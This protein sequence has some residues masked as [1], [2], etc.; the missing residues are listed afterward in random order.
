MECATI[1]LHLHLD[2]SLPLETVIKLAEIQNINL[3][4]ND[5]ENLK[6]FLIAPNDCKNLVQYLKCFNLP[7]GL[8]QTQE[9]L[10]IATQD[11][12]KT[13]AN[14]GIKYAE[15]RFAPQLHTNRNITQ[16]QAIEA[17]LK[18]VNSQND[19]KIGIVLCMMTTGLHYDNMETAMYAV[20]FKDKGVCGIDLAG[21]EGAKPLSEF[22]KMFKMASNNN[23]GIT[24]HAGEAGGADNVLKAIDMGA[25][26]IGHGT[27][28]IES[29]SVINRIVNDGIILEQCIT[30]NVQTKCVVSKQNHPV[31]QL[32]TK[33]IQT[34][35]CTDNMTVSDVT[36][37]SE[38]SLLENIGFT[39]NDLKTLQDFAEKA[40]FMQD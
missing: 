17:V 16:K 8:L 34:V 37:K 19:V 27:H 30:S 5:I 36:L 18:A 28:A 21:A 33:G 22:A 10:T 12:I 11:I 15:I 31:Y 24:I 4:T 1:D 14:Q 23:I 9:S 35:I 39:K 6:K 29:E 38:F 3:P 40:K 26:R 13:L 25:T 32:F 2:G 20:E 7:I